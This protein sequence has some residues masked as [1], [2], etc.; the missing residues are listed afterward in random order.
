MKKRALDILRDSPVTGMGVSEIESRMRRSS[1]RRSTPPALYVAMAFLL[2]VIALYFAKISVLTMGMISEYGQTLSTL[3]LFV[4]D[5]VMLMITVDSVMGV[6]SSRPASWRK[7]M[8]AAMLL[9]LFSLV[10]TYLEGS[11][12][13]T[14]TTLSPVLVAIISIPVGLIMFL[15]SVREFYV[16]PMLDCP[17]LRRWI[18]FALF[19]QLFPARRYRILY[20]DN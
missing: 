12:A 6:T 5:V 10:G 8:R 2:L 19:S 9:F 20:G 17:P 11:T 16:P 3:L 1:I 4:I 18:G 14:F 15:R 13:A 7:V